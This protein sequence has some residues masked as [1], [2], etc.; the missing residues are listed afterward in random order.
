M[1][2]S[3]ARRARVEARRIDAWWRK[4]RDEK[5]LFKEELAEAKKFLAST[6]LLAP[7]YVTRGERVIRWHLLPKTEVKLYF[8]VE[9][10]PAKVR[11]VAVWGA[12]RGRGPQTLSLTGRLDRRARV[13]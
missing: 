7:V 10:K 6:P 9:R 8:W 4:H 12:R 5:E 1:R 2:V 13:S 3:F 11:I